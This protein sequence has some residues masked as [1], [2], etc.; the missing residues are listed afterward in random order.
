[1]RLDLV[2]KVQAGV[3]MSETQVQISAFVV[4]C[5]HNWTQS[6]THTAAHFKV[7][8]FSIRQEGVSWADPGQ[9]RETGWQA[10]VA[11]KQVDHFTSVCPYS[12]TY[13]LSLCASVLCNK[14][15]VP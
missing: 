1:M 10:G 6:V 7:D 14:L 9:A 11:C 15:L 4:Q 8:L 2:H 12:H 5:R 3:N 13:V